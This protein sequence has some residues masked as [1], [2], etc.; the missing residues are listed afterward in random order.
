MISLSAKILVFAG[1]FILLGAL[2]PVR[3]LIGRLPLGTLRKRWYAM[4]ALI[5][6]FLFGYLG[7]TAIFWNSQ[8]NLTDLIVPGVFFFGACFVLLT[9]ILSLQTAM[10]LMRVSL[11]ERETV[12]DPLTGVFNRRYLDRR[13]VE[14]IVRARRYSLPLSILMLDIDHFKQVN[15]TH[16]H[17]AGDQV[18]IALGK[19]VA[20]ALRES[21][22]LARYGGEEFLIITPHTQVSDVIGVAERLRKGIASHGFSLSN[23]PNDQREISVTASIGVAGLSDTVDSIEKLVKV[24]DENLYCAKREGRN[25]VNAGSPNVLPSAEPRTALDPGKPDAPGDAR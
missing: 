1:V 4:A 5:G 24:A 8:S 10:D 15:D 19:I 23:G 17:Q 22:V 25:R 7:Y 16:G 20:K 11:L 12:T 6:L 2:V 14:E 9:A 3:R 21:D 18:L 13:L